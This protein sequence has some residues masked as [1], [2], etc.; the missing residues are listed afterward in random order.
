VYANL[1]EHYRN[2]D[3]MCVTTTIIGGMK[4]SQQSGQSLKAFFRLASEEFMQRLMRMKVKTIRV[5]DLAAMI[6]IG[7]MAKRHQ[8]EFLKSESQLALTLDSIR[9]SWT[10]ALMVATQWCHAG[11]PRPSLARSVCS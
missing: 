2:G 11:H 7:G 1:L 4:L 9:R 6:V 10:I 8:E 3:E 5:S